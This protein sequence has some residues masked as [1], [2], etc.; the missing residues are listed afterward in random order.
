MTRVTELTPLL[1]C[2]K[3]MRHAGH[4]ARAHRSGPPDPTGLRLY[5][6]P[7][8]NQ[9]G[10]QTDFLNSPGPAYSQFHCLGYISC[11]VVKTVLQYAMR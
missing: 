10:A 9:I 7:T 1:K 4:P 11:H 5:S 6:E 3:L 8:R 2:L